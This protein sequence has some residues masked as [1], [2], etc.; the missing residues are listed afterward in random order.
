MH[1]T[2]RGFDEYHFQVMF[3][4]VCEVEKALEARGMNRNDLAKGI[5]VP[6]QRLLAWFNDPTKITLLYAIKMA[7]LLGMKLGIAVYDDGDA[8]NERG[9]VNPDIMVKCWRHLN[10]PRDYYELKEAG[11]IVNEPEQKEFRGNG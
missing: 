2:E 5:E 10:S 11:V 9:P 1:W 8:T 7:R 6:W 4:F 3:D